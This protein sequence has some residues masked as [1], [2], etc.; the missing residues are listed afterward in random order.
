[1]VNT[2]KIKERQARDDLILSVASDLL[3]TQ[4]LLG[5]SMQAIADCTDYSKG[6]IYQHYACKEDILAKLV[7]RCGCSLIDLMK[8]ALKE[9]QSLRHKVVLAS[10]AFLIN[11]EQFPETA[12]LVSKAKSPDFQEKLHAS[13]QSEMAANEQAILQQVIELFSSYENFDC[14]KVKDAAFG[15][16]AMKWGVQDVLSNGWETERLGFSD[17]RE[18]FFR[19]LHIFLDGLGV[20]PIEHRYSWSDIQQQAH[21]FFK[22]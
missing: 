17:P 16:W 14:E 8:I 6:T 9:G 7:I 10:A 19:S 2:R 1:M 3:K 4:G 11:A 20:S 18:Y 15:W 12:V 5:L 22:I 13:I 21:T